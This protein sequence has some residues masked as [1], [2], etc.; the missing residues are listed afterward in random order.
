[1]DRKIKIGAADRP[2]NKM[3]HPCKPRLGVRGSRAQYCLQRAYCARA[4]RRGC[5]V[6]RLNRETDDTITTSYRT[7]SPERIIRAAVALRARSPR[8][9]PSPSVR[10]CRSGAPSSSSAI[11][12]GTKRPHARRTA[13][14]AGDNG[15]ST[16]R[17][18]NPQMRRNN[19]MGW[20]SPD[21]DRWRSFLCEKGG[22]SR[23]QLGS[24]WLEKE[25]MRKW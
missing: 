10:N 22:S 25:S 11:A 21:L 12:S 1:L 5:D 20:W 18:P 15:L 14:L 2:R 3:L 16:R 7:M 8:N 17:H 19:G 13:P 23:Q 4:S 24:G 9:L 6:P